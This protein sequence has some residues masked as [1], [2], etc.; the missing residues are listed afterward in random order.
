[1]KA[2]FKNLFILLFL[3]ISAE[4]LMAQN[5]ANL[6]D[7]SGT[8]L[9]LNSYEDVEGSPFLNEKWAMGDITFSNN[10]QLKNVAIKY[11]QVKDV[12]VFKGKNDSEYYFTDPVKE[13][14][15]V[16]QSISPDG[17]LFKNGYPAYKNLT[18]TSFYEVILDGKVTLLKRNNKTITSNKDFNSATINKTID[19]SISYYIYKSGEVSQVKIKDAKSF[20][21]S[22]DP[23]S[24]DLIVKYI[25][26]HD[27]DLK[28][29]KVLKQIVD[30]FNKLK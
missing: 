16:Y 9:R 19:N 28:S 30:Y 1:M 6:K 15:L 10:S 18:L 17:R 27:L 21:I 8:V 7:I 25:K 23:I 2:N 20:A 14:L 3:S 5:I 13:F 4:N 29:D 11:D 26:E 24:A 22:I 12:L